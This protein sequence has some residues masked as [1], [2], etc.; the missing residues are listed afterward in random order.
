MKSGRKVSSSVTVIP[1]ETF[2][3]SNEVGVERFR[4]STRRAR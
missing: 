3:I 1:A 4:S 2:E